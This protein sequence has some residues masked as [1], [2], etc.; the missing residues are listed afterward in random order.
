M[1]MAKKYDRSMTLREKRFIDAYLG[2]ANGN[3]KEAAIMA[4]YKPSGA[5]NV[6]HEALKRPIVKQEIARRESRR[7]KELQIWSHDY[8]VTIKTQI[9]EQWLDW[10]QDDSL[11][12]PHRIK[13]SDMLAKHLGM[14]ED[15]TK[16]SVTVANVD[17]TELSD[18]QLAA[19]A[20]GALVEM[21]GR[22]GEVGGDTRPKAPIKA[23]LIESSRVSEPL[24]TDK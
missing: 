16:S 9:A 3:A 21:D 1:I 23:R 20:A 13:A 11:D 22:R 14:Y 2:G 5:R 18:S 6:G 12:M 19:I 10:L 17:P 15:R 8:Q 24:S 4:G 7:P